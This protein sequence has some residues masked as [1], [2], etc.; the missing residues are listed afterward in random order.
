MKASARFFPSLVLAAG[1]ILAF[2][3][4][5]E[6]GPV[7]TENRVVQT[8]G[9]VS[10]EVRLKM[11]AGMLRLSGGAAELM[12]GRFICNVKRWKPEVSYSVANGKGRLTV[13]QRQGHSVFFGSHRN[14]WDIQLN[15]KLPIDLRIFLGAGE[16]R[17]DLRGLNLSSLDVHLGVGEVRLDLRG[18][19]DRSIDV[20]IEGG[21]GSG[22]IMVPQDIGI[23]AEIHGGLGSIHAR[24]FRK[25]GRIYT[26]DAFGKSPVVLNLKIN[27]GIGSIDLI[28]D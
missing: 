25:E 19:R 4:C 26:N 1:M 18:P 9:A 16:N 20:A 6:P 14:D 17:L 23:R 13:G 28:E 8:E 3:A 7:M 24:G 12:E 5:E 22:R 11:G 15:D 10:A 2:A 21:I 27:A